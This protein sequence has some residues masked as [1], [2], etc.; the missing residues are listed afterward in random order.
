MSEYRYLY[1]GMPWNYEMSNEGGCIPAQKEGTTKWVQLL[2]LEEP[3]G[4]YKTSYTVSYASGGNVWELPAE[5]IR[6]FFLQGNPGDILFKVN[7]TAKNG[8]HIR[9]TF[10]IGT[11]S[12]VYVWM[13]KVQIENLTTNDVYMNADG[14]IYNHIMWCKTDSTSKVVCISLG[15]LSPAYGANWN[16]DLNAIILYSKDCIGHYSPLGEGNAIFVFSGYYADKLSETQLTKDR[17]FAFADQ[18]PDGDNKL[19]N[20]SGELWG[21]GDHTY[22]DIEI[23][24]PELPSADALSGNMIALY[25]LDS[26]GLT[27]LGDFLWS[28]DFIDN[29]IKNYASPME[30]IISLRLMPV[31]ISGTATNVK[32]GNVSTMVAGERIATQFV[33][34]D[35]GS[36]HI[37][38]MW[39]NQLDFEPATSCKIYLPY[40]G[41]R[42]LDLDDLSGGEIHLIYRLDSLTGE[43]VAMMKVTQTDRYSHN[44]VEY[45]YG[46]NC[47]VAL[48]LSGSNF[49]G[50]YGQ[51]ISGGISAGVGVA[52]KN[53][54]MMASGISS[55][56]T[57]KPS[58]MRSGDVAG[59]SG[60]M[61]NQVPFILMENQVPNM[62][63]NIPQIMGLRSEVY[64]DF[65]SLSGYQKVKE[66][67][68]NSSLIS[69]CTEN[70]LEEIDRLLKEG[71]YF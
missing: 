49:L 12:G 28:S 71:V 3:P 56:L 15:K 55:I 23:D 42:D 1:A 19:P 22:I 37:N 4:T 11:G 41:F 43:V 54:L 14:N 63:G 2:N 66:W 5:T 20:P 50:M 40:I 36:V 47:S 44:S 46:G 51:L 27:A 64:K 32:I 58:Y 62:P 13:L 6:T 52:T 61:S 34:L 45:Y 17:F 70:E 67:K 59:V 29:I 39:G 18:V 48:P 24:F 69:V 25:N 10:S 57:A 9:I 65:S 26:A 68:P 33:D 8:D 60:Y 16:T 7:S 53:P 38:K 21:E 30:N 31:D 35:F